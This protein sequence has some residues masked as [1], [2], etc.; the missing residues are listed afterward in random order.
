MAKAVFVQ[1][2]DNIDYINTTGAEIG[3]MDVVPLGSR[4]GVA[5][6]PIAIGATGTVSTTGVYSIAADSTAAFLTGDALYWSGGKAVKT[7][8]G[9]AVGWAIADKAQAGAV[10]TVKIG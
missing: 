10:V 1:K 7:A 8:G 4:I 5:L 3:Y 2:G 9:V 6:E